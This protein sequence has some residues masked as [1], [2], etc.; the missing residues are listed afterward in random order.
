MVILL[1]MALATVFSEKSNGWLI[2]GGISFVISDSLLGFNKFY[3]PVAQADVLIMVS[4]YFAQF[5]LLMGFIKAYR[6][7]NK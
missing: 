5:S 7:E 4:Y 6:F 3:M 1:L 2:A